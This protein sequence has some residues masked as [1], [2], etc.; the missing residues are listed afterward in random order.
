VPGSPLHRSLRITPG[1]L[2]A[3]PQDEWSP[4]S[5]GGAEGVDSVR[6]VVKHASV[7]LSLPTPIILHPSCTKALPWLFHAPFQIPHCLAGPYK[8]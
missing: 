8:K 5:E 7:P 3:D 1:P 4:H 6:K 2:R